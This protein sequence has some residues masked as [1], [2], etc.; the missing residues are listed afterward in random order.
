MLD[1]LYVQLV[2]CIRGGS[3]EYKVMLEKLKRLQEKVNYYKSLN[4]NFMW[5][6]WSSLPSQGNI[7]RQKMQQ[8][9]GGLQLDLIQT[10]EVKTI[11]DFFNSYDLS[12]VD[13]DIEKALIIQFLLIFKNQINI[14][15]ELSIE[16][17]RITQ[18]SQSAWM[19]A[20]Q[21]NNYE[22][23][24]PHL[25]ALID[26]KKEIAI[27]ID[28]TKLPFQVIVEST[29][30]GIEL[31][32]IDRVFDELK[33]FI[34]GTMLKIKKSSVI[35]EDD[36]LLNSKFDENI[37]FETLKDILYTSGLDRTRSTCGKAV[38]PFTTIIGPKDSRITLNCSTFSLGVFGGLHEMGHAMYGYSGSEEV[39]EMGIFGGIQGG[40]HEGIA[41]F[42]ENIIGKSHS[43]WKLNYFKIQQNFP[44][45]KDIS[46]EQ[47]YR[48]INKVKENTNRIVADEV[49]YSLHPIIR[50]ELERELF[51][52]ILT[53]DEL[54]NAWNLK[55]KSYLG[56]EPKSD[57][58]GVLQ[59][60]HWSVGMFGYFQSYTLGNIFGGQILNQLK[61][62]IPDVFSEIENGN[63]D[64]M[65]KWL[66]NNVFKFSTTYSS[67][68]LIKMISGS[69]LDTKFY[70]D[71]LKDKY[72]KI[73]N[74]VE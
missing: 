6:Q 56:I 59:D 10:D 52:G 42:Y 12:V 31:Q 39:N 50:Y 5:D 73:Y 71:Y 48:A 33:T 19:K 68:E 24:K 47:Y 26:I 11:F 61:N 21:E 53:V 58:E 15:K 27:Q 8:Y 32:E 55:Y 18:E 63:F 49:S 40:F 14:P 28:S 51:S 72:Y 29:D 1:F 2:T 65:N 74:I 60:I 25:K 7:Y 23:F 16:L 13:S 69:K 3:M 41:R 4:M 9:F 67:V 64:N 36:F 54:P 20:R 46:F 34:T 45:M 30:Q 35:V 70:T 38:H 44:E 57:L 62:D 66:V 17:M 43:F 22:I 37:L